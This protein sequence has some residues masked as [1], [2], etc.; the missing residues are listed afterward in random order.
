MGDGINTRF[1]EDTWVG[2]TPLLA[3]CP[4]LYNITRHKN[5]TIADVLSHAPLNIGFARTLTGNKLANVARLR[6]KINGSYFNE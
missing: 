3:Q 4:S 1:L 2:T 6:P 5:V